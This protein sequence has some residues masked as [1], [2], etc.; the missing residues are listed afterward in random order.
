MRSEGDQPKRRRMGGTPTTAIGPDEIKFIFV[1]LVPDNIICSCDTHRPDRCRSRR[2]SSASRAPAV[3]EWREKFK[4]F[5]VSAVE[6]LQERAQ[7]VPGT[8]MCCGTGLLRW[9]TL[10]VYDDDRRPGSIEGGN[11]R[12]TT[13]GVGE[14][15]TDVCARAGRVLALHSRQLVVTR[16]RSLAQRPLRSDIFYLFYFDSIYSSI[17]RIASCYTYDHLRHCV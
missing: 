1:N 4:R 10:C 6:C 9:R 3:A 2:R 17:S 7:C 12:Q 5:G 13:N 16:E 15:A 11:G 14:N 8:G